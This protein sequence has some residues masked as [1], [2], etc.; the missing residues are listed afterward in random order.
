MTPKCE[1]DDYILRHVT[2]PPADQLSSGGLRSLSL[3]LWFWQL[4]LGSFGVLGQCT[5]VMNG[6]MS[7]LFISHAHYFL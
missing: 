1:E 3:S 2:G 4:A 6:A 5:T 7:S